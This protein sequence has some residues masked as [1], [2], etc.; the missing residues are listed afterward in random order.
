MNT[1]LKNKIQIAIKKALRYCLMDR[2]LIYRSI[3][4]SILIILILL[5]LIIPVLKRNSGDTL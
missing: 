1:K 5:L 4:I 2:E 3:Y